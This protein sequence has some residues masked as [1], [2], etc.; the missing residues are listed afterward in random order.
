LDSPAPIT[1]RTA[2]RRAGTLAVALAALEA[3]GPFSFTPQR[4]SASIVP[5]DIQFDISRFLAMP[6]HTYG[7]GVQFQMPP[8]HTVFLTA[9]LERT[10]TRT[11][12]AELNRALRLLERF[13]RGARLTWSHSS[14]TG[15]PTLP[16]CPVA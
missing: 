14:R 11:D 12:Q 6:P 16:G 4:A 9:V 8:V 5:S 13:Y 7:S 1:R 2:L 3:V 10:P 15:C